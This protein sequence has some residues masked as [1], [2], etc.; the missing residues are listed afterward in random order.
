MTRIGTWLPYAFGVF[1]R[2][3]RRPYLGVICEGALPRRL[4]PQTMYI[5]QEDEEPWY[6]SMICPC[7]CGAVLEMN[8][9]PDEKPM[10]KAAI[11]QD[12]TASLRPSVWRKVGCKSHFWLRRGYV[13]WC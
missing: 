3:L 6:A 13:T 2:W 1:R 8:L 4:V 11:E 12:G 7:G 10:W 9:L 5:L